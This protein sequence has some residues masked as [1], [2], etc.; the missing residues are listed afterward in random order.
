MGTLS[1][2]AVRD[3]TELPEPAL[4][5]LCR[6][7]PKESVAAASQVCRCWSSALASLYRPQVVLVPRQAGSP[8]RH[9]TACSRYPPQLF[10]ASTCAIIPLC[11]HRLPSY[12]RS[13]PAEFAALIT[14]Y[15]VQHLAVRYH[16]ESAAFAAFLRAGTDLQRYYAQVGGAA[17]ELNVQEGSSE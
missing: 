3:W 15:N 7:L 12:D 6:V 8:D 16:A 10:S 2:A 13:S 9:S 4:Q 17:G 11:Q 1:D 5:A 14:A